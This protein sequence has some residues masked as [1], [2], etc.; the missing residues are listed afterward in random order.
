MSLRQQLSI[1]E[2]PQELLSL[3]KRQTSFKSIQ[4]I[5]LLELLQQNPSISRESTAKRLT[6]SLRT[7]TRWLNEYLDKGLE[8]YISRQTSS[9]KSAIVTQ[10]IHDGLSKRLNSS[11]DCFKGYWDAHRWVEETYGIKISYFNLRAYIVKHFNSKLKKPRKSHYKKDAQAY[12]SFL[13]NSN[14]TKMG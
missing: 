2:S 3:K 10:E 13:K 14:T 1:K 4:K 8:T 5:Q 12:E 6:I 9:K 11:T 7:Q